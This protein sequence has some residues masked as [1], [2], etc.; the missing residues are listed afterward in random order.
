MSKL[1]FFLQHAHTIHTHNT[2]TH[3]EEYT[4]EGIASQPAMAST[5]CSKPGSRCLQ[6]GH[7]EFVEAEEPIP[8]SEETSCQD[9][10]EP[11]SRVLEM[12]FN[13]TAPSSAVA[14]DSA[15]CTSQA[16][17]LDA[18]HASEKRYIQAAALIKSAFRFER[19]N[20][21]A[22][23]KLAYASSRDYRERENRDP[24]NRDPESANLRVKR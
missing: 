9:L 19:L 13:L 18:L 24:E 20:P 3:T 4:E 10:L 14:Q 22:M 1:L 2:H 12:H 21:E 5:P 6:T 23:E 15:T 16:A 8:V 17:R 7:T 11:A